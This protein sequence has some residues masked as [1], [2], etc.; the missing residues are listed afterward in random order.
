MGYSPDKGRNIDNFEYHIDTSSDNESCSSTQSDNYEEIDDLASH[1]KIKI[2]PDTLSED[3]VLV[4][5]LRNCCLKHGVT[6]QFVNELLGIL[7]K[8]WDSENIGTYRKMLEHY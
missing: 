8:Y 3:S 7:G 2:G 6:S 5:E 1:S 4:S